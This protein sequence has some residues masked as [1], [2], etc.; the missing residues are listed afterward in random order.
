MEV[1]INNRENYL[2]FL[3]V[4]A[5]FTVVLLHVSAVNTYY[6]D[7]KSEDWN[8][9]ML[10]ESF[11]NWSVPVFVMISGSL[12]LSKDYS[13]K[14]IKGKLKR[15][16]LIFYC[17]S[18]LYLF[19]DF[20]NN[21]V[22]IYSE[23][24]LWIQVLIQ[25]H[26]HMWFLIMLFGLYLITPMLRKIV[27]DE[28]LLKLFL[29]ISIVVTF[30]IPS[31]SNIL[32]GTNNSFLDEPIVIAVFNGLKNV[33]SDSKFSFTLGFVSYYM[34]GYW[35]RH[36]KRFDNKGLIVGVVLF[37]IGSIVLYFELR[38]AKSKETAS[39]FLQYDNFAILLQAIGIF[40]FVKNFRISH[41]SFV[42]WSSLSLGIYLLHPFV[43]ELL[44]HFSIT[45]LSFNPVISVPVLSIFIFIVSMLISAILIRIPGLTKTISL[46]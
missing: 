16:F 23:N 45:S 40:A 31:F 28:K 3:R 4:F 37:V 29:A 26:Y 9:F 25:G 13:F 18:I 38:L 17:W 10:Y 22:S 8:L 42:K 24:F 30:I 41:Y 39:L 1:Q 14:K 20:W 36:T 46:K 7:F 21:G 43:I 35:M 33:F 2:D 34:F 15:L 19:F 5:T 27:A 12:L 6:V 32:V 44:Q 11:V